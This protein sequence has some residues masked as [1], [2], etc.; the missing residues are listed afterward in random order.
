MQNQQEQG[1][2]TIQDAAALA[3]STAGQELLAALNRSHPEEM[4]Q[5]FA[6]A[7]AGNYTQLKLTLE[8]LMASPEAKTMVDRLRG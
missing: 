6:Q 7:A 1:K 5:A 2:F 8:K 4:N 3:N